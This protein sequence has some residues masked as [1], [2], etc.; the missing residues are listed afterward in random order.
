MTYLWSFPVLGEKIEGKSP[1][2]LA[3]SSSPMASL[4]RAAHRSKTDRVS[5]LALKYLPCSSV[6]LVSLSMRTQPPLPR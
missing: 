2:M 5:E 1:T 4:T 6:T 3:W